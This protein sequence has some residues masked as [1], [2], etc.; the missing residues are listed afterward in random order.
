MIFEHTIVDEFGQLVYVQGPYE[1]WNAKI[2]CRN[3]CN[4]S[5][6]EQVE[7]GKKLKSHGSGC[8]GFCFGQEGFSSK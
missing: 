4:V 8:S 2:Q 1:S 7:L 5:N 6:P 3:N